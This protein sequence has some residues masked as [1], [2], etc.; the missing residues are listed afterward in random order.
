MVPVPHSQLWGFP[1]LIQALLRG[2][3]TVYLYCCSPLVTR[4]CVLCFFSLRHGCCLLLT[5]LLHDGPDKAAELTGH[6]GDHL[7][8]VHAA[9]AQC[10]VACA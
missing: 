7:A 4:L 2:L 9:L 10:P 8:T 5:H 1:Q 6:G 3:D